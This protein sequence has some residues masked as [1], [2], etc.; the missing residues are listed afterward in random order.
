M[1]FP[2]LPHDEGYTDGNADAVVPLEDVTLHFRFSP[3]GTIQVRMDA[4]G[5][6]PMGFAEKVAQVAKAGAA[7][8]YTVG[9]LKELGL[10]R[11]SRGSCP[12]PG[13]LRNLK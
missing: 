6:S 5:M 12:A 4:Q 11:A 9:H 7:Y 2:F 8:R 13:F 3:W 1:M 10:P